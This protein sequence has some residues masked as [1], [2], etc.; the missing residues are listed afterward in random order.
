MSLG[1]SLS[2]SLGCPSSTQ[3]ALPTCTE[4]PDRMG[5]WIRAKMPHHRNPFHCPGSHPVVDCD[6]GA[7]DDAPMCFPWWW[8]SK[9]RSGSAPFDSDQHLPCAPRISR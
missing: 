4:D 3:A 7:D 2:K 1:G 9:K 5:S 6:D 8:A